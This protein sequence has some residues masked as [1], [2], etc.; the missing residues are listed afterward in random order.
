MAHRSNRIRMLGIVP[1][2]ESVMEKRSAVDAVYAESLVLESNSG[3]AALRATIP[4]N[5]GFKRPQWI[6]AWSA[7]ALVLESVGTSDTPP[8][9]VVH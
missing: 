6:P 1:T 5:E 2:M 7:A 3:P 4:A 8:S 9:P